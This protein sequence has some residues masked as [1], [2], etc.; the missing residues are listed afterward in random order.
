MAIVLQLPKLIAWAPEPTELE[1]GWKDAAVSLSAILCPP[2][3]VLRRD[4]YLSL[5]GER[6]QRVVNLCEDPQ[7][8]TDTLVEDLFAVGLYP[9]VAHVPAALAGAYLVASNRG[10]EQRLA[11]WGALPMPPT[12]RFGPT[13][14]LR[15]AR[16]E[17]SAD[18][19]DPEDRLRCWAGLLS[20]LP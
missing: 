3:V 1:P 6:I 17:I 18:H 19:Y 8:A 20:R 10:T 4:D 9:D 2:G 14:E 11:S 5:L 13:Q 7:E 15:Q 12:W 16:E